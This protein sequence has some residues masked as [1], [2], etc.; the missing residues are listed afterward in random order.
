MFKRIFSSL[1]LV[2]V[3]LAQAPV[4]IDI[5]A[6]STRITTF[7]ITGSDEEL[8]SKIKDNLIS[9][10]RFK[11]IH[12]EG[13]AA[14]L[15]NAGVDLLLSCKKENGKYIVQVFD[16]MQNKKL[17]II[18][19]QITQSKKG[20]H[21]IS[22]KI[23]ELWLKEPGIFQTAFIYSAYVSANLSSIAKVDFQAEN[24]EN[25]STPISYMANL[26][27]F[28]NKLIFSHFSVKNRGFAI[29]AFNLNTKKFER[30]I[31]IKNISAFSPE[32]NGNKLLISASAKGTTGIYEVLNPNNLRYM[33]FSAFEKSPNIR[34][35]LK[36]PGRIS[37][38][39]TAY[40]NL[41]YYCADFTGR[42]QIFKYPKERI[43]TGSGAYFDPV[44]FKNEKIA[45]LKVADGSFNL[46][47]INLK[48][49]EETRLTSHYFIGRPTWSPCG[50]WV[51]A[52]FRERGKK[53][54]IIAVHTSGKYSKIIE[55]PRAARTPI[56]V[57]N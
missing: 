46:I 54:A 28:N 1:I 12:P 21:M 6:G 33:N 47:V 23:Y 57:K 49:G 11:H 10:K 8:K 37:T 25:L 9:S 22:D 55:L 32:P 2:F 40:E 50:N 29:F 20:I 4:V 24:N 36:A 19:A 43:S 53:D 39:A 51:A 38:S 48:T 18:E 34:T 17:R 45:A 35:L 26:R 13:N 5:N 44:L 41:I 56:W 31:T 27:L 3:T 42:P 14:D 15:K 30:L 7:S 52:S 16:V